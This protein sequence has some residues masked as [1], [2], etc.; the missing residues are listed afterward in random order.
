MLPMRI[1]QSAF[2]LIVREEVSSEAYYKR[3]YTHPEWP[4]EKSGVT[5]L[6]LIFHVGREAP[7]YMKTFTRVA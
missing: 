5:I 2:N 4:G 6:D 1:S 3:H 7:N